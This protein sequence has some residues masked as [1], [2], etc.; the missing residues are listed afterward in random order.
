ML[1]T[2]LLHLGWLSEG[3][4]LL[5]KA[6]IMGKKL[7]NRLRGDDKV[8]NICGALKNDL[9]VWGML[10]SAGREGA[11]RRIDLTAVVPVGNVRE[12]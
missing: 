12:I 6:E 9:E 1:S 11:R 2:V 3:G 4:R 8:L 10:K 7:L 5:E